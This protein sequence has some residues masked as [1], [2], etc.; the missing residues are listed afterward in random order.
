MSYF[1]NKK[2]YDEDRVPQRTVNWFAVIGVILGAVVANVFTW[3]I[4]SI[5]GMVVA[6]ICYGA[7]QLIAQDSKTAENA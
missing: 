4:A 2:A 1:M 6:A 5:N 3:G 7:G